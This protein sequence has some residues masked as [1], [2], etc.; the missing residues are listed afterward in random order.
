MG[1]SDKT[2]SDFTVVIVAVCCV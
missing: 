1:K 2:E